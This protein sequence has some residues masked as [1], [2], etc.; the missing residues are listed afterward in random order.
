MRA[1]LLIF[2]RAGAV[3]AAAV[4]LGTAA[5]AR[6]AAAQT[7]YVDL[8][9]GY[10]QVHDQDLDRAGGAEEVA[11]SGAPAAAVAVG[12]AWHDGW[13]V[14]G[15]LSWLQS[16]I[17]T[18]SGAGSAGD[19][20]VWTG[21]LNLF[22]GIDTGWVVTPFLGGGVGGARVA[23]RDAAVAGGT[24]DDFD[25]ALAWQAAAG[26]EYGLSD[27]VI[28]S[29]EYRYLAADDLRLRDDAGAA[30]NTDFRSSRALIGLRF[31]F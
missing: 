5:A 9:G 19:L 27:A 31:G 29:L 14:E 2:S 30:A 20:G 21:M 6:P 18:V 3:L 24:I 1:G 26:F 15:E 13:R 8:R 25:V 22:Y 12:F 4:L 10:V 7:Y 11:F 17:D 16:G 23:L 28:L